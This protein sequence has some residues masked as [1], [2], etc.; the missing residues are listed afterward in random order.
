MPEPSL[1][2]YLRVE[3]K[4]NSDET[5]VYL[6]VANMFHNMPLPIP[7]TELLPLPTIAYGELDS[8]ARASVMKATGAQSLHVGTIIRPS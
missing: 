1:F 8:E 6:D 2:E 7:M 4:T 3:P 5:G